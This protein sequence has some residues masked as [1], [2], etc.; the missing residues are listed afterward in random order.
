MSRVAICLMLTV[1]SCSPGATAPAVGQPEVVCIDPVCIAYPGGWEVRDQGP[2]FVSFAHPASEHALATVGPVNMKAL[3]ESAGR[4]WP[5]STE[6]AV[7]SLWELLGASGAASL[8]RIERL[9]GGAFRSSGSHQDGRLWHLLITGTGTAAVG[10]EVRG[11][12]RSW[13]AHADVFFA[14]VDVLE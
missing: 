3:V 8:E 2:D 7:E 11:P 5:A 4:P 12:N 1:A 10:V 14:G 13:E 6:D 9:T